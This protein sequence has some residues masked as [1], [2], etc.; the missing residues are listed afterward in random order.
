MANKPTTRRMRTNAQKTLHHTLDGWCQT[1][2]KVYAKQATEVLHEIFSICAFFKKQYEENKASKDAMSE[3]A[4]YII[5]MEPVLQRLDHG[6]LRLSEATVVLTHL[7]QCLKDAKELCRELGSGFN[8]RRLWM[9]THTHFG[10]S[11]H[12]ETKSARSFSR[13]ASGRGACWVR[14]GR[15]WGDQGSRSFVGDSRKGG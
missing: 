15:C 7:W 6:R 4:A 12:P 8:W 11:K 14:G 1:S 9:T 3:M 5:R 10:N 2:D 13:P